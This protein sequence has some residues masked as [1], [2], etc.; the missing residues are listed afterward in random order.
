MEID[1]ATDNA[2]NRLLQW[3]VELRGGMTYL[4]FPKTNTIHADH[5]HSKGSV[6]ISPE[7]WEME[8]ICQEIRKEAPR[9]FLALKSKHIWGGTLNEHCDRLRVSRYKFWQLYD[10]GVERVKQFLDFLANTS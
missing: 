3:G 8:A 2:K 5:N 6:W 9:V 4:G 1:T 10:D 7:A